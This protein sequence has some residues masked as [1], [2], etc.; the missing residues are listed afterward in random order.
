[1]TTDREQSAERVSARLDA[2]RLVEAMQVAPAD[3]ALAAAQARAAEQNWPEVTRVLLYAEVAA[4]R[5]ASDPTVE[6]AIS[7]LHDLAEEA[8]DHAMLS[9]ALA[10][11]ADHHLTAGSLSVRQRSY[12]DLARATALLELSTEPAL[13]RATAYVA[14]AIAYGAREL[15]ELEEE[16]YAAVTPVLTQCEIPL[17]DTVVR[18]NRAEAFVHLLCGL[19]EVEDHDGLRQRAPAARAAVAD[20]LRES[21]P[22]AW[23]IEV[24]AFGRLLDAL[25][26]AHP[27]PSVPRP[28]QRV[29]DQLRLRAVPVMGIVHLAEALRAADKGDWDD[30]ARLAQRTAELAADEVAPAARAL[31]LHLA[32][33]AEAARSGAEDGAALRYADFGTHRRW[34]MRQQMVGSARASLH[35]EQLRVERDRHAQAS[36]VDD[37]TG[38]AN[39]RGYSRHLQA[40]RR[41][42]VGTRL[43][44][45]LL[46]IDSF[47]SVNDSHGHAVGDQ[48]LV[49]VADTLA[50]GTRAADLVAR[51]GGDEFLALLDGLDTDA[52][53]R[54][55]ED[56]RRRL[57]EIPWA[58]VAPG[59]RV[60]VSIGVAAG[61][62]DSDP[63]HLVRRADTALYAAKAR[64]GDRVEV[65]EPDATQPQDA[66]SRVRRR[67]RPRP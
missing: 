38:L 5:E 44:V 28:E 16:L 3:D 19:R 42:P 53:H 51:L 23:R 58:Q 7:R 20:V 43:A 48:V 52:A 63:E 14:C 24:E 15:W 62:S 34:E 36:R 27:Q 56:L 32:A 11:R 40:L 22:V 10:S 17:L 60:A 37:L 1:M 30:V 33:R 46:D 64:G 4:S 57:A 35:I 18:F 9:A 47:K 65:V 41:R 12:V 21:L 2:F 49:R 25:V 54:R 26:G 61:E 6:A 45:L 59:L 8:G 55:A 67:D 50:S 39:R 31:A 66:A 29:I 13:E